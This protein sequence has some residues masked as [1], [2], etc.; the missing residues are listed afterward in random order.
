M[1]VALGEATGDTPDA[2][3]GRGLRVF[4]SMFVAPAALDVTDTYGGIEGYVVGHAGNTE[5]AARG[6]GRRPA[7]FRHLSVVR[8][9]VHRRR[10]RSRFSQHRFGGDASAYGNAELRAYVGPPVF[11]SIFPVRFGVVGFADSGRV[12]HA[13]D[14]SNAWHPSAGGGLLLKPIGTPSSCAWWRPEDRRALWCTPGPV[15]VF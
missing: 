10:E 6:Q 12:W 1:A 9:G 2:P 15:F 11:G 14:G 5:R 7:P 4:T 3:P 13:S 8:W